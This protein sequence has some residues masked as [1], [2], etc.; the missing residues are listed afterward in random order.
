MNENDEY[1]AGK[2]GLIIVA[3]LAAVALVFVVAA[4]LLLWGAL[5]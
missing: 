1:E 2:A 5:R 4:A 3:M